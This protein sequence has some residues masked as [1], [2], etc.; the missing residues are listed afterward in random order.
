MTAT[1]FRSADVCQICFLSLL[2]VHCRRAR[3][4]AFRA[5]DWPWGRRR[6][7]RAMMKSTPEMRQ[8]TGGALEK[9]N[10]GRVHSRA[11][12]ETNAPTLVQFTLAS[13]AVCRCAAA[14]TPA[15]ATGRSRQAKDSR[16]QYY[17][18]VGTFRLKRTTA[19]F[20][21]GGIDLRTRCC[22]YGVLAVDWAARSGRLLT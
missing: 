15:R 13:C 9:V 8:G 20:L 1:L 7:P 18:F 12:K 4:L 19:A 21:Y 6:P 16:A 10:R 5:A 14:D 22:T 3:P 11:Q 2:P 17:C